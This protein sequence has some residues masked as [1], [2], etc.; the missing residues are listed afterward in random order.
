MTAPPPG[1]LLSH[2]SG[3]RPLFH[4]LDHLLAHYG[5]GLVGVVVMLESMGAPLPGESLMIAAASLSGAA[6][7]QETA[8]RCCR[9]GAGASA[10]PRTA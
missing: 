9:A 7:A 6:Y 2:R 8:F 4:H 3:R 10:S 5:Y 1:R